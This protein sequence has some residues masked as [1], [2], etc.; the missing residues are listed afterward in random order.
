MESNSD[1]VES[2]ITAPSVQSYNYFFFW[3]IPGYF[4]EKIFIVFMVG[5]DQISLTLAVKVNAM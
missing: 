5:R 3:E 2:D 1:K 4:W